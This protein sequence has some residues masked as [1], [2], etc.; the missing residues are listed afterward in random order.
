MPVY[1]FICKASAKHKFEQFLT[2]AEYDGCGG[3]LVCPTC[4]APAKVGIPDEPPDV[5]I[6]K[7]DN[8]GKIAEDN[9]KKLGKFGVEDK[10]EEDAKKR[11]PVKKRKTPWYGSLGS[12]KEKDL[13]TG[14][15]KE[16]QKKINDYII[17][18]K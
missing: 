7:H 17:E 10:M 16:Q 3:Q 4:H 5:S 9:S 13:F 12:K 8:F 1:D 18:G 2:F 15:K 14:N 11:K 6:A